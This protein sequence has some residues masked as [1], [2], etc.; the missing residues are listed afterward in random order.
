MG[1]SLF[2]DKEGCRRNSPI[3]HVQHITTPLLS[4]LG[5]EDVQVN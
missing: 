1:K 2:N 4:W 5:K 3:E